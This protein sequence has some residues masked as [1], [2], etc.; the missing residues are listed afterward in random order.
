MN[1]RKIGSVYEQVACKYLVSEGYQI[2]ERNYFC[3]IGEIDI[4]ARDDKY[5]AFVEVKYRS[6]L[7]MG[8]PFEAVDR[9]KQ[10]KIYR[11]AQYYIAD[12]KISPD[13]PCRFDVVSILGDEITLLRGAF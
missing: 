10:Q 12:K 7:K 5:L 8:S 9:H 6:N 3:K 4:V 11:T 13:T 2:L 1:K